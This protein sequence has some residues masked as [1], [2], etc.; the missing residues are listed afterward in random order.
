MET[1]RVSE[2]EALPIIIQDDTLLSISSLNTGDMYL[3]KERDDFADIG[4]VVSVYKV[5]N[6][7]DHSIESK[8]EILRVVK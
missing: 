8:V 6:K 7:K 3:I 5:I 4:D 2:Y 1:I